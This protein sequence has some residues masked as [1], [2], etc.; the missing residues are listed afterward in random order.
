MH[1]R[2]NPSNKPNSLADVRPK[3]FPYVATGRR[4][5]KMHFGSQAEGKRPGAH[6]AFTEVD[7]FMD[8]LDQAPNV[9]L[10][11]ML[12]AKGKEAG[13]LRTR[14]VLAERTGTEQPDCMSQTA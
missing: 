2:L 12:E 9:P 11:C 6:A 5:P 7:E 13:P 8:F 3:V 10:D 4:P 1:H 14:G